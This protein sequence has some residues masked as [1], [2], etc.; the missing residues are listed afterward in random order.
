VKRLWFLLLAA[1]VGLNAAMLWQHFTQRRA[2]E[3]AARI[4]RL[5]DGAPMR[6]RGFQGGEPRSYA[7]MQERRLEHMMR[8]LDLDEAQVGRL[9]AIALEHAGEMDSL[10]AAGRAERGRIRDLLGAAEVDAAAVRDASRRLREIDARIATRITENMIREV[11]VLAPDQRAHY[12]E[13]MRFAGPQGRAR[14]GR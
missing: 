5:L 3:R 9:R 8:S 2:P 1:S 14:R 4:E 10:R 13:L 11:A 7:D 6:G 12:L